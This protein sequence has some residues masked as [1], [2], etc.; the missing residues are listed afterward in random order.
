MKK[1]ILAVSVV[2]LLLLSKNSI[3][4]SAK[5]DSTVVLV[6]TLHVDYIVF[7]DSVTGVLI[8]KN[9]QTVIRERTIK[10]TFPFYLAE[11]ELETQLLTKSQ[12]A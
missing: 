1:N 3:A 11:Q 2:V 9:K 7:A 8:K 4:Q 12:N 6:D 10:R 5:M